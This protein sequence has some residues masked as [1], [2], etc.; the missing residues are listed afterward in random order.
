MK[1]ILFGLLPSL[2]LISSVSSCNSAQNESQLQHGD[3]LF[4]D[5]NC[6][7]LCDAIEAVTEGVDNR[8]FSHCAM[9]VDV[10]GTLQV[11]E[12]TGS[13]VQ[14]TSIES[15]FKRSGDTGEI[16]NI[17][18]GR[19]KREFTPLIEEASTYALKQVGQP[20][21]NSFLMNN[22]QFYCSELLYESFKAANSNEEFFTLS[23]MTFKDPNNHNFF[24]AWVDYY[25]ELGEDIPEGEPGLNPGSI[26]RSEKI[27]IIEIET[28]TSNANH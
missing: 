17:Y 23:P 13:A 28:L 8:D 2:L 22:G 6:G 21:Y 25:A 18:V 4:Q 14:L 10:D 24:P 5:L 9:V 3:L 11:V 19:V 12:A 26:S 1:R 27:D 16:N 20:Y 7:E 15:F